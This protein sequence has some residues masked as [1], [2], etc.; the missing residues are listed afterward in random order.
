LIQADLHVHTKYSHDSSINP[1]T[2]VDQLCAHQSIKA[3][4]VTDHGSVEGCH[5]VSELASAYPDL[6][7]IPG[8][9]ITTPE[10]DLLVLGTAELPPK[11]WN[12]KEIIDFADR[13]GCIVIVAH[14]Y[15]EYGL[16]DSAKN[17]SFDA[18]EILN[19]CAPPHLNRLAEDL[20]KEMRLP[21][22]AGTDAHNVDELWRVYTEIQASSDIDDVLKAITKGL[23]KVSSAGKSIRF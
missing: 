10:G 5:R 11:P 16:G 2:L 14:P 22:V 23:V 17:H 13:N 7:V 1:K 15:R 8:V 20:A 6:L 4:A 19:G 9:E 3:V 21:G 12:V 18:I